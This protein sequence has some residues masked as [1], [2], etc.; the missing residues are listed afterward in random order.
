M[1]ALRVLIPARPRPSL[2]LRNMPGRCERIAIL[3]RSHNVLDGRW[4]S[5]EA[6][7]CAGGAARRAGQPWHGGLACTGEQWAVPVCTGEQW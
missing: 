5:G 3:E 2:P 4:H 7:G 1:H 6:K